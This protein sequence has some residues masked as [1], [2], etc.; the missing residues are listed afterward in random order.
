M[1]RIEGRLQVPEEHKGNW[2]EKESSIFES[3]EHKAV[4]LKNLKTR[5]ENLGKTKRTWEKQRGHDLLCRNPN[6]EARQ[7]YSCE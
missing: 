1:N 4:V 3:L 7:S 5:I 6:F 2:E